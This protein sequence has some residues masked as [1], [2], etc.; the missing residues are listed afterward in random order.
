[1]QKKHKIGLLVVLLIACVCLY[2]FWGLKPNSWQYALSRRIPKT[3]AMVTMGAAI[4]FSSLIFQT[5][6]NNRILTPSVMGLDALYLF[7]QTLM[8]YMLG[9]Q[10][11]V[12]IGVRENFLLS[13]L[14]MMLFS[15]VLYQLM[16]KRAGR[17]IYFLLLI[18]MVFSTFFQSI[19]SFMQMVIDPNEFSI[20]QNSSFASFN[21]IKTELLGLSMVLFLGLS[22]LAMSYLTKLDVMALGREHAI[23]LGIAYDKVTKKLLMVVVMMVAIATALVGPIT[24]LG[25][26]VVNL[27][28]E[29]MQTHKHAWLLAASVLISG[30]ALIGGQFLV[31]RLFQF[32]TPLSIV[33]NLVGGIY[34]I[35]LLLKGKKQ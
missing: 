29:T 3:L 9:D 25:L 32:K 30:I 11:L 14:G 28:R 26:L 7:L 31:E 19:T 35:Y 16:F 21:N 2:L 13:V 4:A 24:F 27:A 17:S 18:G 6:T 20:V 5:L 1:M 33:I 15:A 22:T 8:V 23:N 10:T 34:F 12:L